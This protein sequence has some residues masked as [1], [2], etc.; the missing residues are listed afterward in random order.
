[1]RDGEDNNLISEWNEKYR[2]TDILNVLTNMCELFSQKVVFST[3]FNIEDQVITHFIA[4]YRMP[5]DIFTLDTGRMFQEV[6]SVWNETERKYGIKI[7]AY[8][9]D[10]K[11]VEEMVNKQGINGFYESIENRKKCCEVRKIKPLQR[12]LQNK[13]VWITGIR[14]EQSEFRKNF[15]MF[16]WDNKF[17]IMKCNPL[18]YWTLDEVKSFIHKNDVP[19]C[20]LFD[21]GFVS[22]GCAPCTR[23]IQKG[24]P[25]R[26][27]RWWWENSDEGKKECGLHLK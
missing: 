14:A 27:G 26:A 11:D 22:I 5:I 17:Q 13:K 6:Y 3:S 16:E 12:A 8:F 24:E 21:K 7:K 19:Y 9:P 1:M 20:S 23:A 15:S 18:I 4:K 2:N 10:A 25:Y